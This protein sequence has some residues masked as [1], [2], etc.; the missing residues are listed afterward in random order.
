MNPS[1]AKTE[2]KGEKEPTGRADEA[3]EGSGIP[4]DER[5]DNPTGTTPKHPKDQGN[6]KLDVSYINLKQIP[7]EELNKMEINM[8]KLDDEQKQIL[9]QRAIKEISGTEYIDVNQGRQSA[10][11][12]VIQRL[13]TASNLIE[14]DLIKPLLYL[15]GKPDSTTKGNTEEITFGD[16]SNGRVNVPK[17]G[18]K[19]N[20]LSKMEHKI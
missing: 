20:R 13:A 17:F 18:K 3:N 2:P 19:R 5:T 16:V 14:Q 10:V 8:N 9:E 6:G 15:R 11:I 7:W 1:K 12:Q 4:P